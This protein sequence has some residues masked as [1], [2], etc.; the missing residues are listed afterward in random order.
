[1]KRTRFPA[2]AMFLIGLSVTWVLIE[3]LRGCQ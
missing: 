1:M 3:M 2:S